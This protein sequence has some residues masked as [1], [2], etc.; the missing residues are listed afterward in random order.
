MERTRGKE[1]WVSRVG[2]VEE[3]GMDRRREDNGKQDSRRRPGEE[4]REAR[5]KHTHR[6]V[7]RFLRISIVLLSSFLVCVI[8][9][10]RY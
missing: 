2:K 4:S 8:Y 1:R 3:V 10:F 7:V 6:L 5:E 9:G